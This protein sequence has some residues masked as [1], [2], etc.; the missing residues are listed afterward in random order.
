MYTSFYKIDNYWSKN[1]KE[2][3][4][5]TQKIYIILDDEKKG[6]FLIKYFFLNLC[7]DE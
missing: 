7:F 2:N 3:L 6:L 1:N 5:L 4:N